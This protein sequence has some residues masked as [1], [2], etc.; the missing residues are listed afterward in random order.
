VLA[1]A[2]QTLAIASTDSGTSNETIV[3]REGD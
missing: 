2:E 1:V 3:G